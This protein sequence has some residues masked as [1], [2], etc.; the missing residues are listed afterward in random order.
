MY[1]NL[2]TLPYQEKVRN[3]KNRQ[4]ENARYRK[5][6]K[7]TGDPKLNSYIACLNYY[8]KN[9]SPTEDTVWLSLNDIAALFEKNK[10]TIS[11]HIN[12]IYDN[13]EP[14]RISTVAK[15]ATVQLEGELSRMTSCAKN[16]HELNG[17][18]HYTQYF[19]LDV[20]ISV[21]Y[22]V[23]SKKELYFIAF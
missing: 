20:I 3:Y 7:K 9:V 23:E 19:N 2:L 1:K 15:N 17:Q 16:A 22:R 6:N 12:N 21:D 13:N 10:S 8:I 4:E 18:K 14:L 11:R 5:K